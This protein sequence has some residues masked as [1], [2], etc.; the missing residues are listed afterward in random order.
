MIGQSKCKREAIKYNNFS[1]GC[2]VGSLSGLKT[3]SRRDKIIIVVLK[4]IVQK[5]RRSDIFLHRT[6]I[7]LSNDKK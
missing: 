5:L 6:H 2:P 7:E 1:P 3:Q 4:K